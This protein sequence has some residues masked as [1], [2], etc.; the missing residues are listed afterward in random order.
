MPDPHRR[1]QKCALADAG[2][3]LDHQDPVRS[4]DCISDPPQLALSFQ[5]FHRFP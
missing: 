5:E 1:L 2:I 4:G 3:A